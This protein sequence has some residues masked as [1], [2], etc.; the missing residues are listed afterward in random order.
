MIALM[1]SGVF[2]YDG[3]DNSKQFTGSYGDTHDLA[4]FKAIDSDVVA[5]VPI[6]NSLRSYLKISPSE[7]GSSC[8]PAIEA[9]PSALIEMSAPAY[10]K[11]R[12]LI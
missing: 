1:P 10:S 6:T 7:H 2:A 11:P 8:T 9:N 4:L 5:L 3:L 12:S